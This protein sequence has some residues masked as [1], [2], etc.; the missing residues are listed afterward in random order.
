MA[1]ALRISGL[2]KRYGSTVAL[3]GADLEIEQGSV[4]AVIGENGAGKSTLVKVLAGLVRPDAGS[5]EL[6]GEAIELRRPG[7]ALDAGI[8]TA[9]QELSLVPGLS[10]ADNL[11]LPD[12]PRSRAGF[13]SH[14][15]ARAQARR[16]LADWDISHVNPRSPVSSLSLAGR[17]QVEIVNAL[18]RSPKLLILD[19]PTSALGRAEVEW[20]FA[21]VATL[22]ELGTTVIFVSHRLAEVREICDSLTVLRSGRRAGQS[23]NMDVSDDEIIQMMI[24]ESLSKVFPPKHEQLGPV[25]LGVKGIASGSLRSATFDLHEGEVLGVAG[26]QDHGQRDLFRA[27]FGAQRLTAGSIELAGERVNLR[28]PRD[29]IRAGMGISLVPEDRAREGALLTMPG[30]ANLTLPSLS[31]FTTAGWVNRKKEAEAVREVLERLRISER[32]LF[33]PVEAFSG[34]NQQKIVIGKWLLADAK[35]LL[36]YDPTRGVD[37]K[38]KT[39]I[40]R[41]VRDFVADGGSVLLYSTDL[42]EIVNLCTSALVCYRG[43]VSEPLEGA[44]LTNAALLG[45]MLGGRQAAVEAA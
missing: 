30:R 14:A 21:Q 41:L 32:A 37:I 34:G 24:G 15:A 11:A 28:S 9:F 40:F 7:Q 17:Q 10:V 36:L 6:L 12:K 38:T 3:A 35:V 29:A 33:E 19:E 5:L 26:L 8:A 42:D 22:R 1:T 23:P 13:V 44:G 16:K 43:V 20:L 45:A 2:E 27:L 25:A 39:E 18:S 4:H 31:R